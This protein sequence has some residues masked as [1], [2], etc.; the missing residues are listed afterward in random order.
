MAPT[1][2]ISEELYS[3]LSELAVGFDT[4]E[5][6]ISRLISDLVAVDKLTTPPGS[7]AIPKNPRSFVETAF[8]TFFKVTPRPFG[9]NAG[10]RFGASDNNK[11]VQWNISIDRESGETYLGVNL[12]GMKYKNWPIA[13][14]LLAETQDASLPSFA[15]INTAEEITVNL[16]RDAWQAAARLNIKE[17]HIDGSGNT[18]KDI[19]PLLW[20]KMVKEAFECLN[21]HVNYR[22]RGR[23]DVT[24]V[25]SGNKVTKEVSPHLTFNMLVWEKQPK[26]LEEAVQL[27]SASHDKLLPLYNWVETKCK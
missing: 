24:L 8:Q 27:I 1:I 9:Q 16:R 25:K 6:V 26:T 15:D 5:N 22:G 7:S 14:L 13:T 21:P 4:P 20:E 23:M 11:G 12:E 3:K 19:S 10:K 2:E 17:R 18:L